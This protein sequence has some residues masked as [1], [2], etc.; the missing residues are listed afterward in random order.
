MATQ[1]NTRGDDGRIYASKPADV[2]YQG[3]ARSIGFNPVQA[4]NE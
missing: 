2:T 3:A 1:Q 4:A